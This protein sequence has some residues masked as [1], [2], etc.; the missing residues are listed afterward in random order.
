VGIR[1]RYGGVGLAYEDTLEIISRYIL[2][3]QHQIGRI[4]KRVGMD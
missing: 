1:K 3:T 2:R 4:R